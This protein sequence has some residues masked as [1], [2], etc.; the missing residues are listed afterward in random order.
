MKTKLAFTIVYTMFSFCLAAQDLF[1]PY[2]TQKPVCDGIIDAND[3]WTD[4]WISIEKLSLNSTTNDHSAQFQIQHDDNY[5]FM[6]VKVQ[7][8]TY[9][10][11]D[12]FMNSYER[13]C[14]EIYF[15]MDTA[16]ADD[17]SYR[18]G[19]WQF[20]TQRLYDENLENGYCD[21]NS[22][23][24]T[25]NVKPLLEAPDFEFG[26]LASDTGY[27]QEFIFPTAV[28]ADGANFDNEYIR[29]DIDVADNTGIGR[30]GHL[31]WNNN[32]DTQWQD[33]RAFGVAQLVPQQISISN[34]SIQENSPVN[35]LIGSLSIPSS[36]DS[37]AYSFSSNKG[38]NDN[39]SFGLEGD[40][41]ITKTVFDYENK[42]SYLIEITGTV[43]T[44]ET[45]TSQFEISVTNVAELFLSDYT[46]NENEP[47]GT[48]VAEIFAGDS[49]EKDTLSTFSILQDENTVSADFQ[50]ENNTIV[51]SKPFN[52]EEQH[53]YSILL[54]RTNSEGE[55]LIDKIALSVN[56]VNEAPTNIL[57]SDSTIVVD[58]G[59]SPMVGNL[60]TIDEDANDS[61]I[62][63]FATGNGDTDN[64]KFRLNGH[65]LYT[66]NGYDFISGSYSIRLQTNDSGGLTY[67][68]AIQITVVV[69]NEAPTNITISQ[70]VIDENL[71]AGSLVGVLSTTDVNVDD[72]FTYRLVIG[73]LDT[74]NESFKIEGNKLLSN[75]QFDYESQAIY[76]VRI[77][78][79]DSR[80]NTF[81]KAFMISVRDLDE[82]S[83]EQLNQ[84]KEQLRLYPN[85][86]CTGNLNIDVGFEEP[87]HLEVLNFE[88]KVLLSHDLHQGS[89]NLNIEGLLS[90]MYLLKYSDFKKILFQQKL[91]VIH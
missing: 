83:V 53:N 28:L 36:S 80:G 58:S 65:F 21:G 34:L 27:V 85:P 31:F 49:H 84:T 14:S 74:D 60:T 81:S 17:W 32:T 75:E 42:N 72:T 43:N 19:C 90:G 4:E 46:I 6:A 47:S 54:Q 16:V 45:F 91:V 13:D 25:W 76:S 30:T 70:S 77:Q 71:P 29:F 67:S 52:Y 12:L 38:E 18:E 59:V 78:T 86:V 62:Y 7:D 87:I 5:I 22:G 88:G 10:N 63:T 82:T 3:A 56:D 23:N 33:T 11:Q 9:F 55:I 73:D 57:L 50:I 2:S 79:E 24:N 20:R 40:L 64:D 61:F 26:V 39:D 1:I 69:V 48:L 35:S 89:N 15:A 44:G 41:L 8:A 68:K 51:S 66:Y 37:I